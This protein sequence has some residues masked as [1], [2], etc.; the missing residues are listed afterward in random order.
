METRSD[1]LLIAC[2]QETHWPSSSEFIKRGWICVSSGDSGRSAGVLTII[3]LPE[4]C[5]AEVQYQEVL[6]G[7]TLHVRV[8]SNPPVDILNVYQHA[9]NPRKQCYIN[10]DCAPITLLLQDRAFVLQAVSSWAT[11]VPQ[12][13]R[14]VIAGDFNSS[15]EACH[16]HV[17]L[18]LAPH[19]TQV[20]KDRKNLQDL[21]QRL[22][23][24]AANTWRRAGKPS[25]T[26]Q[27]HLGQHVQIDYVFLRMP[28]N[29]PNLRTR[30]LHDAPIVPLSG[31]RRFPITLCIPMPTIP[32]TVKKPALTSQQARAALASTEVAQAVCR[33]IDDNITPATQATDLDC[34]LCHLGHQLVRHKP[35]L[36]PTTE[37]PNLELY[38]QLKTQLRS[39]TCALSQRLQTSSWTRHLVTGMAM[40]STALN[41]RSLLGA[42]HAAAR[43]AT[44]SHETPQ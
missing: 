9:W 1:N 43:P 16:P 4:D 22:G 36:R 8:A 17:G 12:R 2:V 27:N 26:F 11:S 33:Q 7:R 18:G 29:V 42:W 38:W 19:R 34:I 31:F 44:A 30:T 28:C 35:R 40:Q 10:Q 5:T 32:R 3:R 6:P 13:N 21:V 15:L 20:H 41:V 25:A 37:Q 14:L 39:A 23:L 24:L